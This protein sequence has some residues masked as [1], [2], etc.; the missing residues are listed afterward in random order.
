MRVHTTLIS[1]TILTC[2]SDRVFVTL[3]DL[4]DSPGVNSRELPWISLLFRLRCDS[5]SQISS[6]TCSIWCFGCSLPEAIKSL[7]YISH[8][9]ICRHESFQVDSLGCLTS[10]LG[11]RFVF[12]GWQEAGHVVFTPRVVQ[13]WVLFI[14]TYSIGLFLLIARNMSSIL[15]LT[16]S[17]KG[18][19][20]W[21][22]RACTNWM[23]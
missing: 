7:L 19:W 12:E 13:I 18:I 9:R 16:M 14:Y 3:F 15:S 17:C 4:V 21:R 23:L 20:I 11:K 5:K 6:V 2:Q 10:Q 22:H 1:N 8:A